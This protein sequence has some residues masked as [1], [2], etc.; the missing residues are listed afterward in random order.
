MIV[1]DEYTDRRGIRIGGELVWNFGRR[2]QN[3][4]PD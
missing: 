3:T 4:E 2:I 1:D